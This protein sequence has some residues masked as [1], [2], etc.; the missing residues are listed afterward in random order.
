MTSLRRR[1][2][3]M[4][5]AA[6]GFVWLG[7]ATWIYLRTKVEIEH[8][9]D[10][11][12]QEAARMVDSLVASGEIT[13]SKG[14]GA[15]AVIRQDLV[16]YQHQLACQIWSLDGRLVARSS[17]APDADLTRSAGFS[18]PVVGGET[19]R[20]YAIEDSMLGVR[21]LVGDR[22]ALRERL[23]ANLI[24]GLMTPA[25]LIAPL[26]GFFIWAGIGRG[27]RPL[28]AMA[29]ELEARGADDMSP[30]DMVEAPREVRPL[31]DAL[32]GLFAKLEMARRHER[33]VT[34]FA[35]HEL[36]TPLAG[37]KTQAQ[38]AIAATDPTLKEGALRQILVSVDRTARL[39][40]QL[41]DLAKIDAGSDFDGRQKLA[42]W[43]IL[44][45]IFK[46]L[47]PGSEGRTIEVDPA[48]KEVSVQSNR[49]LL[50][51][52][53]R[54]LHENALLYTSIGGTVHWGVADNGRSIFVE[55]DGP[56]IPDEEL[57]LVTRRFF[58]GRNKSAGGAGL[59][60]A[61]VELA[62]KQMGASL[63]VSNRTDGHGLRAEILIPTA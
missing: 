37:L 6:T 45:E 28:A 22:L 5:I 24:Q 46:E 7:A 44:E 23:V 59:G 52:A 61:I 43:Q 54:N 51:L 33:E 48:L 50:S 35:A 10:A 14:T 63:R 29:S 42:V 21:V 30:I 57:T 3:F 34:A 11:R 49:E 8:V 9:L 32:N 1:L 40:R 15:A 2:F 19:W 16:S 56:G 53:L 20:V 13:R 39:V 27:L 25:L 47:K 17:G 58:R 26:L 4:L 41:L 38:V 36:R 62:L 18:E 12:L 60:L 31:A 55:D